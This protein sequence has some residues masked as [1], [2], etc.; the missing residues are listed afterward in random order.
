MK[1]DMTEEKMKKIFNRKILP[2]LKEYY[3]TDKTKIETIT[4]LFEKF[5][6]S[7]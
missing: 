4:E 3:F 5:K 2:L 1:K 7:S 6:L